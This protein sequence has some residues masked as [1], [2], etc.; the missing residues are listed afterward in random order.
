MTKR[1]KTAPSANSDAERTDSPA[2][3]DQTEVRDTRL[4][5]VAGQLPPN[6]E[7][8]TNTSD[9]DRDGDL[10]EEAVR[11]PGA[12]GI[13]DE[14]PQPGASPQV[15]IQ[16]EDPDLDSSDY[17]EPMDNDPAVMS[18]EIDKPGPYSWLAIF[19][20]KILKT[21]LLPYKPTRKDSPVFY[22][23]PPALRQ[24][25]RRHLR[26]VRVLLV[27]DTSGEGEAFLWVVVSSSYSPYNSA[28]SKVLGK[29]DDFVRDHL[30][31]FQYDPDRR[32]VN[33]E[34]RKPGPD[35]PEV[36]L[37]SR[38]LN[39]LLEEA[40]GDRFIRTADHA[41]YQLLTSGRKLK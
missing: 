39:V 16:E 41:L 8:D 33:V 11:N 34:H 17:G 9:T 20:N 37:P 14:T 18:A 29:D 30:F 26:P 10:L 31:A 36:T 2:T 35:D 3:P 38:P 23:V 22:Y 27:G 1:S 28:L 7:S 21:F 24:P 12:T 32:R 4:D 19:R 15:G 40:L 5:C 25:V 6:G 13:P